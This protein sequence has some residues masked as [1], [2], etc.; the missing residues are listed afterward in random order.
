MHIIQSVLYAVL[1]TGS[2]LCRQGV[3]VRVTA[4]SSGPPLSPPPSLPALA[5]SAPQR[6]WLL[7]ATKK[8]R[9]TEKYTIL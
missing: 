4:G 7:G 5:E 1:L 9:R 3:G 6:Q 2:Q 8:H